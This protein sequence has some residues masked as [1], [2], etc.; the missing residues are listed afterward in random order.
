MISRLVDTASLRIHPLAY[1]VPEMR[2][3]EWT[4]FL[5][6]VKQAGIRVP[7]EVIGD[8]VIDGRHRLKA[9]QLLDIKQVP[10]VDAP[11]NGDTAEV[12]MMKA[13]VLRRHLTD[14]QRAY[15]A[16]RWKNENNHQGA[17]TDIQSSTSAGMP[18]GSSESVIDT[19]SIT[20]ELFNISRTKVDRATKVKNSR[21]DL[22]EKVGTGDI[23]LSNAYRQVKG[24]E[25][26]A[27]I[28]NTKPPA[29]KYQVIVIDPPW[30][31]DNRQNDPTH[32]AASPYQMMSIDDIKKLPIPAADDSILWL[33]TTNTFLPDAFQI[34]TT[35]GFTY[36]TCLTWGKDFIGLGDWLAGQ[37]EHCLLATKGNY[38]VSRLNES[39]LLTAPKTHHSEKPD[40]FYE[41]VINLCPG[42][43]I[44]MFAR[45][46]HN[47]F[48][49][50]GA[51]TVSGGGKVE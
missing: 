4:Q 43:R 41:M 45:K 37:T 6:D 17:R 47:G 33:W 24:I 48:T 35:W 38:R 18:C 8:T 7:L 23:A 40:K 16:V 14:D 2:S 51:E 44:D 50:W 5:A 13:A 34:L 21:P 15:L 31:Y 36:R 1:I 10:V 29:G 19:R 26:R 46:D 25:E 27:K 32:R 49:A 9:A 30:Q 42:T 22:F 3:D 20:T 39:T 11:I 28:E 12:Y